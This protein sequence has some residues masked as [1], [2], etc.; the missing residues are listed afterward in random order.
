ML[1]FTYGAGVSRFDASKQ[2]ITV[3]ANA[4][5]VAFLRAD[6]VAEPESTKLKQALL[7]YARTRIVMKQERITQEQFQ[8]IIQKSLQEQSK[9]W[10]IT[11]KIVKQSQPDSFVPPMLLEAVNQIFTIHTTRITAGMDRLPSAVLLMLLF[12]AAASLSVAGFSAG[13]TGQLNRLRM[14]IFALVLAGV[15]FII[16]DFDQP[17][18]GFIR[19]NQSNI[20]LIINEMEANLAQ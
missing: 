13:V 18:V 10:L 17:H 9:L 12:V 3:E 6:M 2:S 19:V 15:M 11:E 8:E 16:Y 4:I 5:R 20:S 1:A 7:D 14:T